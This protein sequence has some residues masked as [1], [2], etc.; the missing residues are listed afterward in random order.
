MAEKVILTCAVTGGD[1]SAKRYPQVP[2]SPREIA[3]SS[4]E[5]ARAGAAIVHIHVRD[6]ES[7]K[8]SMELDLYR[9]T[10]DRIR[11]SD[12]DVAINLTTGPGARFVPDLQV[13]NGFAEGSN[14]RP[15][16]ERARHI[17]EL[18]PE[19]C[20]LD[21]GSLNFGSGALIN[22]PDQVRAIAKEI[23]SAGV[24]TEFEIFDTGHMALAQKLLDDDEVE[25]PALFQFVL[26]VRWGT[27]ATPEAAAL[28]KGLTPHGMPWSAFGVGR[29]A[30]PMVAQAIL[31]NGHTRVGME[32]NFYLSK[33]VQARTNAELV[34]RAGHIV[35]L[36]GRDLATPQEARRM[37]G[38]TKQ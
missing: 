1:D 36:L 3:E 14:V 4:I 24:K 26:G 22:T 12:T 6:P 20:S 2:V 33:G 19:I 30:F 11:D 13:T 10:V 27:P 35:S 28:L 31:L 29:W 18:K 32:D 17:T 7:G 38:L 16:R 25:R 15:P 9:E 21:M 8:P 23:R 34:E 37:L 5:A